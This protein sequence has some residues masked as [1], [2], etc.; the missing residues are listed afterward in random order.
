MNLILKP[1]DLGSGK[2]K[3]DYGVLDEDRRSIGR[4]MLHPFAVSRGSRQLPPAFRNIH[5]IAAMPRVASKRWQIS[6]RRGSP[7]P[8]SCVGHER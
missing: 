8:W 6:K 7:N 3:D 1:S 5:M 2:L 4:I